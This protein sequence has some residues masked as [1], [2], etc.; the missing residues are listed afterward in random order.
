MGTQI[1]ILS[2][3][4]RTFPK[5]NCLGLWWQRAAVRNRRCDEKYLRPHETAKFA[6]SNNNVLK[7]DHIPKKK[8][9]F[10]VGTLF[11][12]FS[13][14]INYLLMLGIELLPHVVLHVLAQLQPNETHPA[15]FHFG[16]ISIRNGQYQLEW[17]NPWVLPRR[18]VHHWSQQGSG[19]A[20]GKEAGLNMAQFSQL[21]LGVYCIGRQ[22]CCYI[23]Q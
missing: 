17:K 9:L 4:T 3:W 12:Y 22:Y 10:E 18:G 23:I 6:S 5:S 19:R 21:A 15:S 1:H 11:T 16:P 20:G 2:T 7:N 14:S 13:L 8:K